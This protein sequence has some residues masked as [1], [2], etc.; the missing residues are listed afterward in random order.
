M[1][2]W[3]LAGL[4][5]IAAAILYR[6]W[7]KWE[8]TRFGVTK[9]EITSGKLRA[10]HQVAVLADLHGFSYGEKNVRLLSAVRELKPEAIFIVGDMIVSKNLDTYD[11]ALETLRGLLEIAPV[12][13][14]FG[15]HE[16]KA[17]RSGQVVSWD[18]AQFRRCAKAMGAQIL[19]NRSCRARLKREVVRISGLEIPLACFQRGRAAPFHK[20]EIQKLLGDAATKELQILL[21]HNPAY[22]DAYAAWG[23]DVALC[24]HNHGGLVRI[25]GLGGLLSP[26]MAIFPKYGEGLHRVGNR[27]VVTSRG[28]GTHTLHIRVFNRAELISITLLPKT[29]E[30]KTGNE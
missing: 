25:P 17:S 15:N 23:A 3:I 2:K 20:E 16:T 27:C 14:S 10:A 12:Y 5:C 21:A 8:L 11:S 30:K 22:G 28:L 4:L 24:G 13:Y 19:T 1:W 7:Q 6:F 29:L 9:Y 26:Q 18:F